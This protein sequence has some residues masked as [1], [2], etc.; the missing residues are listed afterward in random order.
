MLRNS[1]K[2]LALWIERAAAQK[3]S[4][5]RPTQLNAKRPPAATTTE[6]NVAMA[7]V[8]CMTHLLYDGH[9][10]LDDLRAKVARRCSV[11]NNTL[12]WPRCNIIPLLPAKTLNRAA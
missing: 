12:M 3:P 6:A 1:C 11:S 10:L 2:A 5:A 9:T 7:L 4:S 8:T